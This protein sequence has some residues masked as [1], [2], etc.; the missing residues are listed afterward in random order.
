[1]KEPRNDSTSKAAPL[2]A[3]GGASNSAELHLSE[4][5]GD[6][7]PKSKRAVNFHL[8]KLQHVTNVLLAVGDHSQSCA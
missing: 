4:E 7:R 5:S 3:S 8:T 2:E 6:V 1:M